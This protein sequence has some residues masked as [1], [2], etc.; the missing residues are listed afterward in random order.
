MRKRRLRRPLPA[1]STMA[2]ADPRASVLRAAFAAFRLADMSCQFQSA[3]VSA[4]STCAV[5]S[6]AITAD[7]SRF[8]INSRIFFSAFS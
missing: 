4:Q 5:Y 8:T 1:Q 3:D 7:S 2:T 6:T